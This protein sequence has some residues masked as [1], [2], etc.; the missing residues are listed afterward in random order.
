MS[1]DFHPLKLTQATADLQMEIGRLLLQSTQ[2]HLEWLQRRMAHNLKEAETS[3]ESLQQP[4]SGLPTGLSAD[5]WTGLA[6]QQWAQRQEDVEQ[7]AQS[8]ANF[9]AGVQQ[10]MVCWWQAATHS[11]SHAAQAPGVTL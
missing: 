9:A 1:Q 8:Q 2:D 11:P 4:T 10:A 5:F 3:M 6:Q 7:L